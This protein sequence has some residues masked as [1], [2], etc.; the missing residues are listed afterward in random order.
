MT[1]TQ[2]LQY[3]Q[4]A[5]SLLR[6]IYNS[7][8]QSPKLYAL[9]TGA[10]L[11]GQGLFLN[12]FVNRYRLSKR[13][14]F[15]PS[16]AFILLSFS[17]AGMNQFSP[18]LLANS[19][20]LAALWSLYRCYDK[21]VSFGN[22]FNAG[23]WVGVAAL[24]YWASSV[25]MLA[26]ALGM[27]LLRPFDWREIVVLLAGFGSPVLWIFTYHL[28]EDN[29]AA[30]WAMDITSKYGLPTLQITWDIFNL[31]SVAVWALLVGVSLWNWGKLQQKT[32]IQEQ[33]YLTI[34]FIMM[35]MGGLTLLAQPTVFV[36]HLTLFTLPLGV[37]FGLQLQAIRHD[38]VAELVHL[39]AMMLCLA[40][41]YQYWF[42]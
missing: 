5:G 33:K 3:Q 19:F 2:L 13:P 34:I 22:I 25:Y 8:G 14:S 32:T 35:L 1:D 29:A 10:L 9:L 26:V 6:G 36:E 20:L 11:L 30:W 4:E 27:V 28:L 41:Q 37:L 17:V 7:L 16:I 23:F 38:G 18:T 15:I 31:M 21:K 24:C 39:F 42:A 12:M 40:V